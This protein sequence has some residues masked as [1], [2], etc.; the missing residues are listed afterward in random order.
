[1]IHKDVHL[2]PQILLEMSSSAG[3]PVSGNGFL[4]ESEV[5]KATLWSQK[6]HSWISRERRNGH[7]HAGRVLTFDRCVCFRNYS[8][9]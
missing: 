2:H 8:I 3:F 6:I 7:R 9:S 1:M 4:L 5:Q